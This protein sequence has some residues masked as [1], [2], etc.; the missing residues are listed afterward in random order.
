PNTAARRSAVSALIPRFPRTISLIRRGGTPAARASAF[1]LI[2]R[3]GL[4]PA[5]PLAS[6][7]PFRSVG[8]LVGQHRGVRRRLTAA[9]GGAGELDK[10]YLAGARETRAAKH[11]V[12]AARRRD[13]F[14][15]SRDIH[16]AAAGVAGGD[17][18]LRQQERPTRVVREAA[19]KL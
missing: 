18:P 11:R 14:D 15:V 2:R 16:H 19:G 12:E 17:V 5:L 10:N 6:E 8:T 4:W 9:Y 7:R 1:W 3:L 13:R